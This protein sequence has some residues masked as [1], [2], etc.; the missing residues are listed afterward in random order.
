MI[1]NDELLRAVCGSADV[2]A[3]KRVKVTSMRLADIARHV[4]AD[5]LHGEIPETGKQ[6]LITRRGTWRL[7]SR[8]NS[9]NSTEESAHR[10]M[11]ARPVQIFGEL[12]AFRK[13]R[14]WISIEELYAIHGR[15]FRPRRLMRHIGKHVPLPPNGEHPVKRNADASRR[16]VVRSTRT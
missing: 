8:A 5:D 3:F 12:T 4:I 16:P 11:G 10:H 7:A 1:D 15:Q 9:D 14:G 13:S 2:D 6:F